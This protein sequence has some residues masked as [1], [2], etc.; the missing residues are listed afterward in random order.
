MM[1]LMNPPTAEPA[2]QVRET[3]PTV[4]YAQEPAQPA[5]APV[6]KASRSIVKTFSWR[7]IASIDTLILSFTV[8]YF[9]GVENTSDAAKAAG[10]IASLEVPNKL[11]LYYFHERMWNRIKFG[12]RV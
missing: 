12:R 6:D 3:P 10:I 7:F 1:S 5:D 4:D 2:T 11:L 8:M 9:V